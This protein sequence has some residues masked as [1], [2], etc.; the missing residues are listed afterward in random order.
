MESSVLTAL[1]VGIGGLCT[2]IGGIVLAFVKKPHE[3]KNLD[4]QT[5]LTYSEIAKVNADR[6]ENTAKLMD[7]R[8]QDLMLRLTSLEDER[9]KLKQERD[10]LEARVKVLESE[11]AELKIERVQLNQRIEALEDENEVLRKQLAELN[12]EPAKVK[13]KPR[14]ST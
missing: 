10:E 9:S 8:N 12:I 4:A 6:A 1:I 2:G 5:M 3:T 7:A 13:R 11:S 14:A